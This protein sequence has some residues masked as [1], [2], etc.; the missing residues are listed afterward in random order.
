MGKPSI[1]PEE[2]AVRWIMHTP[3]GTFE[4]GYKVGEDPIVLKKKPVWMSKFARYWANPS[5]PVIFEFTLSD[6]S[7]IQE[8]LNYLYNEPVERD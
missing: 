7:Y 5:A 1:T 3:K 4:F 8:A 6:D 2:V